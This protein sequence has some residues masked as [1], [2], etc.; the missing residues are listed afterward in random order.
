MIGMVTFVETKLFTKL[1]QQYL[2]DDEYGTL[3]QSLI[4]NP[5]AGD[6]IPGSG[7]V[8]KLRWGFAGRGK[9]GGLRVIYF[10]RYATTKSDAD[11][12]RQERGGKHFGEHV[13]EDQGGNRCRR[14]SGTSA[15]R[16]SRVS[17]SSNA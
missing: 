9:R 3:Q 5:E 2:T 6:V 4:V 10:L 17:V 13:E 15:R 11:A 1:V 14:L 12:V 16:F 7:G 8:R